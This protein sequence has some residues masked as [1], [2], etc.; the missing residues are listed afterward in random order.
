M[1][2]CAG[3]LLGPFFLKVAADESYTFDGEDIGL[4]RIYTWVREE[5]NTHRA[6]HYSLGKKRFSNEQFWRDV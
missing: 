4:E 6:K 5:Y 3:T 1:G 2:Y